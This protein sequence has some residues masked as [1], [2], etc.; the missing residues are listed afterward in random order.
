M[1]QL[2]CAYCFSTRVKIVDSE[3]NR[4]V[5]VVTCLECGK[6]SKIDVENPNVDL[7]GP[8]GRKPATL[9]P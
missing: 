4:D 6:T 1:Q 3:E 5:T 7:N 9:N 8:P 2:Q